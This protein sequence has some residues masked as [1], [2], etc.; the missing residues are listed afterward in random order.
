MPLKSLSQ[1]TSSNEVDI[2]S[3]QDLVHSST[4][5]IGLGLKGKLPDALASKSWC[6]FPCDQFPFYRMTVLSNY[7]DQ[8]TPSKE[9]FSLLL[10]VSESNITKRWEKDELIKKCLDSLIKSKILTGSEQVISTWHK[11]VNYGYPVPSLNR[12]QIVKE[13]LK[14]LETKDIYSRGRFGAWLY[15]ISNQ[16]HSFFQGVEV[17]NRLVLKKNESQIE[18][19][20]K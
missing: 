2:R 4:N 12:T 5:S 14:K 18:D 13:V 3:A 20:L 1:I 9:Y 8:N 6:Y 17:I 11:K 15:E 16:D 7:N 10:E 19:C